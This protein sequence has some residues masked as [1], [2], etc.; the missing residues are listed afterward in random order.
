MGSNKIKEKNI[1]LYEIGK[2]GGSLVTKLARLLGA[3]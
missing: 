1:F 2:D 3:G